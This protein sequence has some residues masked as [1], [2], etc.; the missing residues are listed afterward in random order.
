MGCFSAVT[1]KVPWNYISLFVFTAVTSFAIGSICT[2]VDKETVLIALVLTLTVFVGLTIFSFFV[3]CPQSHTYLVEEGARVPI[4]DDRDC[5]AYSDRHDPSFHRVLVS[6]GLP[7]RLRRCGPAPVP[8]YR[9][10]LLSKS[11]C[12]MI[13]L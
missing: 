9:L 7:P 3:R 8:F 2:Y 1:K 11:M 12:E 13:F 6:M 4:R 5:G 10:R